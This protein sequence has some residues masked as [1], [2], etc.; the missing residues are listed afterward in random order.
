MDLF[1]PRAIPALIAALA[2]T[3]AH[4]ACEALDGTYR[5]EAAALVDGRPRYLS[6]L[7][8]GPERRRLMRSEGTTRGAPG[9]SSSEPRARQK[10]T[11]LATTGRL[12]A[13]ARGGTIEFR[14]SA[15]KVLATIGIGEGWS[16]KGESLERQAERTAGLGDNIRTER[17]QERLSK[18]GGDLVYTETVTTIE[19]AGGKPKKTETRF[20]AV[21]PKT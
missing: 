3:G 17:L 5:Y 15:G 12:A 9:F 19:P 6:D 16:C 18:V 20:A 8:L 2:A 10:V 11:H 14:D 7:T 21:K 13:V 1:R 4:A